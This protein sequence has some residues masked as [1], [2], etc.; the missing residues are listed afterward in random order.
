M[1]FRVDWVHII[2][3]HE[4]PTR[5]SGSVSLGQWWRK[6][7]GKGRYVNPPP[8]YYAVQTDRI[9]S[10][11]CAL[12][13]R[14]HQTQ[15]KAPEWMVVHSLIHI[16]LANWEA[17]RFLMHEKCLLNVNK[18]EQT[19]WTDIISILYTVFHP[20]EHQIYI[21]LCSLYTHRSGQHMKFAKENMRRG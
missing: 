4:G 1:K 3:S 6:V 19:T 21:L 13:M 10:F 15:A 17:S 5:V 9:L 18:Q 7:G 8:P 20:T 11:T 16:Q 12:S 14:S 2:P